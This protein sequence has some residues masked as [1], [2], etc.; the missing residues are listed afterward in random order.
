MHRVHATNLYILV[1]RS[2]ILLPRKGFAESPW[3]AKWG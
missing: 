3:G 1:C 2:C